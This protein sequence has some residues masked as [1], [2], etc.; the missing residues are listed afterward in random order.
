MLTDP[1]E[2]PDAEWLEQC[3]DVFA[4]DALTDTTF[5]LWLDAENGGVSL[6]PDFPHVIQGCASTVTMTAAEMREFGVSA[7]MIQAVTAAHATGNWAPKE[8]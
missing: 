4:P 3:R 5:K 6:S 1:V 2:G 7:A 8:S